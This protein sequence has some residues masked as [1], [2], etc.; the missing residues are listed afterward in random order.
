M[1]IDY[2]RIK[3]LAFCTK[4]GAPKRLTLFTLKRYVATNQHS[5]FYCDNC[6]YENILPSYVIAYIKEL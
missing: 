3:H 4:C 6:K 5:S 1:T 2:K